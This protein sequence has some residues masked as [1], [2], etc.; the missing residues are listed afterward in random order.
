MS[1]VPASQHPP[2]N[3]PRAAAKAATLLGRVPVLAPHIINGVAVAIGI[4]LAQVAV[5]ALGPAGA[6]QLASAGAVYASLPHLV[7]RAGRSSRCS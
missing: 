5:L 6:A 2:F 1:S 7:D 4:G 3:E